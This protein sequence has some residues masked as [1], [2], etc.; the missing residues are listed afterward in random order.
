MHSSYDSTARDHKDLIGA[1]YRAFRKNLSIVDKYGRH[2]YRRYCN[3]NELMY[4]DVYVPG[5]SKTIDRE[6]E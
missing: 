1:P 5:D 6:G 4:I 3:F 2:V